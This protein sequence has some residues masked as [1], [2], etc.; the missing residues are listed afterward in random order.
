MAIPIERGK[1]RSN[2]GFGIMWPV[3]LDTLTFV[4]SS[5]NLR[6]TLVGCLIE[7]SIAGQQ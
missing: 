1:T 6:A 5:K 4:P 7:Y 2:S 3:R